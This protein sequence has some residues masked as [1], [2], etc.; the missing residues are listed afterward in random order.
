MLGQFGH[1]LLVGF[2]QV[3]L[4]KKGRAKRAHLDYQ[5]VARVDSSQGSTLVFLHIFAVP[6]FLSIAMRV[7]IELR[8]R[9]I[10][11]G[12]KPGIYRTC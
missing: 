5:C 4:F 3:T 10:A 9:S 8:L 11:A 2:V 6:L 1:K 7:A 12:Q